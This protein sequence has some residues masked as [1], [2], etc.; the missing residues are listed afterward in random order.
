MAPG[1]SGLGGAR[2]LGAPG[3]PPESRPL[4]P[5]ERAQPE[6]RDRPSSWEP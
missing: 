4:P 6:G 5:P 1:V 3:H 2:P